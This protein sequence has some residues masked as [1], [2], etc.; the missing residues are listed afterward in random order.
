MYV[1]VHLKSTGASAI[2]DNMF[3]GFLLTIEI[4]IQM[5]RIK[6]KHIKYIRL[7]VG[8]IVF[9]LGAIF[10]FFPFIPLGYL[11][12]AAGLFLMAYEIPFLKK[13]IDKLKR[14]DKKDRI[15]KVE[16]KVEE[17]ENIVSQKIENSNSEKN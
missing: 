15:E 9:I 17:A 6:P 13:F 10:M 11:F 1:L 3:P 7:V 8:F 5:Q 12:L 14:R 2:L 4:S 16:E